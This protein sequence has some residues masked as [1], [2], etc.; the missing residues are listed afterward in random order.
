MST[1][2][3]VWG[4]A[5]AAA[6][7]GQPREALPTGFAPL[8]E[9]PPW[10]SGSAQR[11]LD[12]ARRHSGLQGPGVSRAVGRLGGW[13]AGP[14]PP[15]GRLRA[16][17]GARPAG[18]VGGAHAGRGAAALTRFPSVRSSQLLREG[19]SGSSPS[20]FNHNPARRPRPAAEAGRRLMD[21][22]GSLAHISGPLGFL[23]LGGCPL[24]HSGTQGTHSPAALPRSGAGLGGQGALAGR[25]SRSGSARNGAGPTPC[26]ALGPPVCTRAE[27]GPRKRP[28][29]DRRIVQVPAALWGRGRGRPLGGGG[30]GGAG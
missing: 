5:G 19:L 15:G 29:Q 9:P 16:R 1:S 28:P 17:R 12:R 27:Q 24:P 23:S 2:G 6:A 26:G 20:V 21:R 7:V 3:R 30:E 14:L 22:D 25:S 11:G 18:G 4:G 10:A 8:S 13:G